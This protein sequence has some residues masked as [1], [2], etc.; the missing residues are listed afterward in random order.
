MMHWLIRLPLVVLIAILMGW[1]GLF[2]M[3][4]GGPWFPHLNDFWTIWVLAASIALW[5]SLTAILGRRELS[6]W[7][8]WGLVSPLL[9]G[10]LVCPPASFAF[11]IVKGYI[12]F[13]VGLTTGLFVGA[14]FRRRA[15]ADSSIA[16]AKTAARHPQ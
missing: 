14:I 6:E 3:F 9:G 13:P 8:V 1:L 12:A 7:A 15:H 4:F 11:V 10:A 16:V 2:L 5:G